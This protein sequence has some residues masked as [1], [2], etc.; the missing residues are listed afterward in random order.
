MA[1]LSPGYNF[2]RY[3]RQLRRPFS[4]D[5]QFAPESE[6]WRREHSIGDTANSAVSVHK[7]GTSATSRS[8][9]LESQ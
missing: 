4:S 3:D 7:Q 5:P 2:D 8:R 1:P 9:W 6:I